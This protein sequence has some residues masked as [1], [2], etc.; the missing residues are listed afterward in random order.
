MKKIQGESRI[1]IHK[2]QIY[3]E[4]KGMKNVKLIAA[5]FVLAFVMTACSGENNERPQECS[6]ESEQ[7]Q[8]SSSYESVAESAAQS[9]TNCVGFLKLQISRLDLISATKIT[10]K[11]IE[12]RAR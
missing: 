4:E 6:T 9:E 12:E 11:S 5:T 1:A 8:E 7:P 10:M 3:W 2:E